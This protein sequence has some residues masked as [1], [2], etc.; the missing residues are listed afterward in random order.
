MKIRI[1]LTLTFERTKPD[2]PEAPVVIESQGSLIETA[3][4]PRYIGFTP[5]E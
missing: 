2:T 1:A 4:Q 3:P 5:E